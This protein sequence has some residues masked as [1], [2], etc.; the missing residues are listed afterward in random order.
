MPM[1]NRSLVA[2]QCFIIWCLLLFFG[3]GAAYPETPK[4]I[5]S[6]SKDL[7]SLDWRD[8]RKAVL[9]L[10]KIVPVTTQV[11]EA[12]R[13]ALHDPSYH[14]RSKAVGVINRLGSMVKVLIPDLVARLK[15]P[16]EKYSLKYDVVSSLIKLSDGSPEV[17]GELLTLAKNKKEELLIRWTSLRSLEDIERS[18]EVLNQ[19]LRRLAN[20]DLSPV[21]QSQAWLTLARLQPND[22]DIDVVY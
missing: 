4:I 19:G 17:S 20:N 18:G 11:E 14:V 5:E 22:D 9:K 13:E 7:Q 12:L 16:Q 1:K 3:V 10:E 21:I 6:L 8:R 2:L 15:N